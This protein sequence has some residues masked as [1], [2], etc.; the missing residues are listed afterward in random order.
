MTATIE[1]FLC[2]CKCTTIHYIFDSRYII[3]IYSRYLSSNIDSAYFVIP[4]NRI[5]MLLHPWGAVVVADMYLMPFSLVY[6]IKAWQLLFFAIMQ[7]RSYLYTVLCIRV[8]RRRGTKGKSLLCKRGRRCSNMWV[9]DD[10][11]HPT[12]YAHTYVAVSYHHS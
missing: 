11:F 12:I 3:G 8:G 10:I 7:V 4:I 1:Y 6:F 9:T 5:T 2:S